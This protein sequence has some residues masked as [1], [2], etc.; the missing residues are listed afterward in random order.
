MTRA[1]GGTRD[2]LERLA[3][4]LR[5]SALR[6]GGLGAAGVALVVL[7]IAAWLARLGIVHAPGWVLG[8][9]VVAAAGAA[10]ALWATRR[11]LR[12]S[13]PEV[14]AHHL[15]Q[16]G[17]FR[18][19]GIRLLLEEPATGVS[20]SL[21]GAA[22]QRQAAAVDSSG[23]QALAPDRARL[24]R[25]SRV[26][27]AVA[28][29]G[30]I[31]VASAS[32]VSGTAAMLW[33]PDL[34]WAALVAP[35]TI[36]ASRSTVERGD[37]VGLS[38]RAA[39]RREAVLWTRAPGE[40]WE[41]R[42]VRLDSLGHGR[43]TLGPLTGDLY[44]RLTAGGRSSDTITVSVRLPAFLG[45]LVVTAHYPSYLGA[46][47]E[48]VPLGG[49]TLLLPEGT[50]LVTDGR[51]TAALAEASWDGAA[52]RASLTVEGERFHGEFLPRTDGD[53]TLSLRTT[54]GTLVG[55]AG[56]DLAVRLVPD[57]PPVVEVPVPGMDT[58][59]TT[60]SSVALLIDAR[61]DHGLRRLVLE[62][63]RSGASVQAAA[64]ELPEA[65][66][67]R[68]LL[69]VSL[70][71]ATY[72]LAPGD[73]LWYRLVATDNAPLPQR[74]MS[75]QM[76]LIVPSRSELRE[77]QREATRDAGEQL[78]A[79][80]EQS[81]ALERGTEDLARTRPRAGEGQR[82]G[83]TPLSLDEARR[84]EEVARSQEALLD[85]VQSLEE[86][87]RELE[88]AA[89]AA[90]IADTA[91]ARRMDEI[92]QELARAMSPELKE[93]L[94]ALQEALRK[95]DAPATREALR[96][97]SEAQRQMREALERSQELFERA[98]LEGEMGAM[99][100][101]AKE[102]ADAQQAWA[103]KMQTAD[104]ARAAAEERAMAQRADSLAADIARTAEQMQSKEAQQQMS[105]A[106]EA[107]Q[108][109]ADQMRKAAESASQGQ[110]QQAG[111][112]GKQAA[113]QMGQV[114][115]QVDDSRGQQQEEWQA[116]VVQA[117]DQA[118]L[119]TTRLTTRQLALAQGFRNGQPAVALRTEQSAVE[120][121]ARQLIEQV[122]T[123]G[124]K[125]ALVPPQIAGALAAARQQMGLA[126]EAIATANLNL[127]EGGE[128]AGE[129][130]DALNAA[131]FMLLRARGNVSNSSSG[132]G[133]AEA[134]E[135]MAQMAQQQGGLGQE[136]ASLLP[137]M[138]SPG[139]EQRLQELAA[140]QRQLSRDLDRLQAETNAGAAERFAEEARELAR[141]MESGRL[142][143]ATIARQERLFRR[144]LDAGRTLQG[145]EEDERK[146]RES[147]SAT[148]PQVQLPS[149]LR[150]RLLDASGRI[151]LPSWEEL[152]HYS[153]EER[154]LVADYFRRLTG[155][156]P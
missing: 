91:F 118:L 32:P 86:S 59:E 152:Q 104:T 128:R 16:H 85:E 105:Q 106:A 100:Q 115:E 148:D 98:A 103:E 87:L 51:A 121:G 35:L 21:M 151:R 130:V 9:W 137:M 33:R 39:G 140:Q 155:G 2:A 22:D 112:Q 113:S 109:A 1:S 23:Y 70:E 67:D 150:S 54:E 94:A 11:E 71:I 63:R 82:P 149:A 50:R 3:G 92:R 122:M 76:L 108:A 107:A 52:G 97:L 10:S 4:P 38:F 8:T 73:T 81:R 20:P 28:L 139:A 40:T 156:K 89:E 60:G 134:M 145:E 13:T 111:Q 72:G 83:E 144:M 93:K 66:S 43:E 18:A 26:A 48:P 14:L 46:D 68:A 44:A 30:S 24:G 53:W 153:P 138:G 129:A 37:S 131:A 5:R 25:R 62:T 75:R 125:N 99:S 133:M 120:E 74:G 114:Q 119:E 6:T 154:R 132:S 15:E 102:L 147:E 56:A 12:R 45:S 80:A 58:V 7:G 124:G 77:A 78:D 57:L 49:D 41:G 146:E 79:L 116:E 101:E 110:R 29:V 123:A 127:R 88:R 117:L 84:A 65:E 36:T 19:G 126:R 47:P 141:E 34:A 27:A 90:G 55:N 31:L 143:P 69:G 142:D 135:Q 95:L 61:D 96:D 17:G 64:L 42:P 136:S